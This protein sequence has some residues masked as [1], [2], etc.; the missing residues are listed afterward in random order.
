V[1]GADDRVD[2]RAG[3]F[4]LEIFREK[5]NGGLTFRGYPD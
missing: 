1:A 5:I 4:L 3:L 2:R